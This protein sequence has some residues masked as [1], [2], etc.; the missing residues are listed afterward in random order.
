ML[1]PQAVADKLNVQVKEEF[2]SYWTYLQMSYNLHAMGY[3]GFAKWFEAQAGEEMGHATK[4]AGYLVEVGAPVK[5]AALE[6]PRA[7]YKSVKE[8]VETALEHEK[9]ITR[10]INECADVAEKNNDKATENFLAWFIDEQI[11]EVS[12]A[13][14]LLD[15]VSAAGDQ[16]IHLMMLEG[17]IFDLRD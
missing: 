13:Q 9:K 1:I 17:R 11:E 16:K 6:M 15:M 8:I 12:T 4:I 3:R 5:L 14:K 2:F 10:L 7:D